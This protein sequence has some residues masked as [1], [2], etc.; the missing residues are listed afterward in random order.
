MY[1]CVR[2]LS[3]SANIYTNTHKIHTYTYTCTHILV[4][5][6]IPVYISISLFI[7]I[8]ETTCTYMQIVHTHTITCACIYQGREIALSPLLLVVPADRESK[9]VPAREPPNIVCMV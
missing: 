1:V 8:R 4:H 7:C 6:H 3:V 2:F 5:I 9:T